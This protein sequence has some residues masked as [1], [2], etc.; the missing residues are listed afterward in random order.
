MATW[1]RGR[2]DIT[3]DEDEDPV[4]IPD[5]W[6][7][8]H[9][10]ALTQAGTIRHIGPVAVALRQE[11]QYL[12]ANHLRARPNRVLMWALTT[13]LYSLSPPER[14]SRSSS[15]ASDVE[16]GQHVFDSECVDCHDNEAGGGDPVSAARI[17]T[18]LGLSRGVA[19]GTGLYRPS[20][21]IRVGDAGPCLHHGAVAT[22]DELF[23]RQR[24]APDYAGP[25]G[26]GP[27]PGHAY[28]LDLTE[29]QRR[30]LIAF[31]E[32]L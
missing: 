6:G 30:G 7:L 10:S 23:S 22:L 3:E 21:L 17:G 24:L 4:A 29:G 11:T 31:L 14:S 19:R 1:G 25:L 26:V 20:A 18:D 2:A 15:A 12:Y 27:V 9:Q 13:Y 8:R 16:A 28:G 5:L 32:T